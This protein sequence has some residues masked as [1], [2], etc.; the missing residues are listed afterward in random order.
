MIAMKYRLQIWW[1][2]LYFLE[3]LIGDNS[4]QVLRS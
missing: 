3:S 2:I 4:R 1:F